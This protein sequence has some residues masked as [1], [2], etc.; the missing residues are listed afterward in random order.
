MISLDKYIQRYIKIKNKEGEIIPFSFNLQQQHMYDF[1]KEDTKKGKLPRY[2]VLKSRQ[3]GI[4]T[5]VECFI[6]AR[7]MTKHNISAMVAAHIPSSTN[8]LYGMTKLAYQE[9]PLELKPMLKYDN[10]NFLV[11]DNPSADPIEYAASPGLKSSLRVATAGQEHI[12]RS[13]TLQYVHLSEFAFWSGNKQ[14]QL[15]GI[16]QAVPSI[17]NSLIVI[18]STANGYEEFKTLWDKAVSGESEFTPVFF[19]WKDFNEY[20]RTYTGFELTEDERELQAKH[21]LTLEQLEWRRYGINTLCSGDLDKFRQEYPLTPDEAFIVS[22]RPYFN[23]ELIQSAI[24]R[25]TKGTQGYFSNGGFIKGNG[26]ITIYED[27]KSGYPYVIG[28]D[29]SGEGSDYFVAYVLDNTTGKIVAKLRT[30]TDETEYT[31][32]INYLGMHYNNALIAIESNFS[33]YPIKTLDEVYNYPNQ[34][35]RERQDTFTGGIVKSY[36]FKTTKVTRPLILANLM[37]VLNERIDTLL[38]EDLLIEMLSFVKND[39]GRAEAMQGSHDDCVMAIAIALFVRD[40]QSTTI[41]QIQEVSTHDE[42]ASFLSYG[43]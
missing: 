43:G 8:A 4:S 38:D 30:Q 15:T 34:Y 20:S 11:F 12:G 22:G 41:K 36:G 23:R 9:L 40:Q 19:S 25:C 24:N 32:Q 7:I 33:T 5:F 21:G 14:D 29:T 3:M 1:I 16:I 42:Y 28:S 6:A 18:E 37:N 27:V 13:L 10:N 35:I 39:Q 31:R 17:V 26:S 2:I